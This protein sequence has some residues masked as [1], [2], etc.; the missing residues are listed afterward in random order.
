LVGHSSCP[1]LLGVKLLTAARPDECEAKNQQAMDT[2]LAAPSIHT[3]V[4]ANVG[5]FYLG[6]S[7]SPQH[8]GAHAPSRYRLD[9]G[10]GEANARVYA[11]GLRRTVEALRAA[12]KQVVLVMDMPQFSFFPVRCIDRPI[13]FEAPRAP[14]PCAA[15]KQPMLDA[16]ADYRALLTQLATDD[17][18][19]LL[20]DPY[21]AFCDAAQC[22]M[23]EPG[24]LYYRDSHHLS[25]RG[26]TKF[27][28]AFTAWLEAPAP[29]R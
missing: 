11:R 20:Y 27:A 2:I 6:H 5:S 15:P 17:P 3:V 19:I 8:R 7:L 1:P 16:Q 26:A 18:G 24:M 28:R 22:F 14:T 10:S 25:M 9:D 13:T 4:L 12:G 21:P 23:A 29:A